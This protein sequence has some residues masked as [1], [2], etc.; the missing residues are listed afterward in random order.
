MATK[1][2]KMLIFKKWV[3]PIDVSCHLNKYEHEI[4]QNCHFAPLVDPVFIYQ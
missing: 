1:V 2:F 3:Q 4:F